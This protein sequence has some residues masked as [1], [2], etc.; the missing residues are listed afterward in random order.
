RR[1]RRRP[2][3]QGARRVPP[4][5]RRRGEGAGLLGAGVRRPGR[6]AGRGPAAQGGPRR[7]RGPRGD[8]GAATMRLLLPTKH[9]HLTGAGWLWLLV[10]AGMTALAIA[11]NINLLT[12]LGLILLALLLLNAATAGRRLARLR[13]HRPLEDLLFADT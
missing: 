8:R 9:W 2:R 4:R 7:P 10:S 13:G 5:L 1:P 12:L 11:K 6:Q 3:R